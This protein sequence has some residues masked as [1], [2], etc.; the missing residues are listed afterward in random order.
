MSFC[1]EN[2]TLKKYQSS[3]NHWVRWSQK[4]KVS[5]VPA[6]PT[7][8]ALFILNGIQSEWSLSKIEGI[9][10]A[11]RFFHTLGGYENPCKNT[12]VTEM[13]EAAKR[14]ISNN[15]N[16]KHP[17]KIEHLKLLYD[18]RSTKNTL[19]NMRT[20]AICLIGYAGFMRFSEIASL[21]N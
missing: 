15:K 18:K 16:K 7:T 13:L 4:F 2:N 19:F 12:L 14:C 21:Q 6:K 17:I 3:F 8:V 10:Y 20:L 9:F 1:R 11:I 5:C